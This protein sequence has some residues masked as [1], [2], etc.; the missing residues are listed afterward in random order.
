MDFNKFEQTKNFNSFMLLSK[1]WQKL[2]SLKSLKNVWRFGVF[3][4]ILK[5]S[6]DTIKNKTIKEMI[7]E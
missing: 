2:V 4:G 6:N 1:N 7:A 5:N 3:M